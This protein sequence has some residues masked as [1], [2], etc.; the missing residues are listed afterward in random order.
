MKD[1]FSISYPENDFPIGRIKQDTLILDNPSRHR[2]STSYGID[3]SVLTEDNR[4]D[5]H[6]I[7]IRERGKDWT[8]SR[9]FWLKHG[10]VIDLNNGRTEIFLPDELFGA[11]K[12][13]LFEEWLEPS[14]QK[15][16]AKSIF[17]IASSSHNWEQ[18][19]KWELAIQLDEEYKNSLKY[20]RK[21]SL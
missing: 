5:Y 20:Q 16:L 10:N 9:K 17:D 19:S 11:E 13:M 15:W 14:V 21:I 6:Y 7:I 3:L 8:T 18:F 1:V 4:M 2:Q 12:A